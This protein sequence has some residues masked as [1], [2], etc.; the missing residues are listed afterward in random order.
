MHLRGSR[1][2]TIEF[3]YLV[4]GHTHDLIDA[5]FAY[6]SKALMGKSFLSLPEM[7]ATLEQ[8]MTRPPIWKHLRDIYGFKDSQPRELSSTRVRGI[9]QPNHVRIFWSQDAAN[10]IVQSKHW[11]TS[12]EW[13]EPLVLLNR[14]QVAQIALLWLQLLQPAWEE[15]YKSSALAW[16]DKLRALLKEADRPCD[17]LDHCKRL[18]QHEDP[19]YLP[20]GQST[21]DRL[22]AILQQGL[23]GQKASVPAVPMLPEGLRTAMSAAFP[24]SSGACK[25]GS[26]GLLQIGGAKSGA[27]S[28]FCQDE[29]EVGMLAILRN[30]T[31]QGPLGSEVLPFVLGKVL[32]LDRENPSLPCVFIQ[33]WLPVPKDKYKQANLF[34]KWQCDD[35]ND[36]KRKAS[37]P[38]VSAGNLD[39]FLVWP[40]TLETKD[41]A[42]VVGKIPLPALHFLRDAGHMDVSA[43][44]WSF[45]KRGN[46]FYLQVAKRAAQHLRSTEE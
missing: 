16:L 46:A 33:R 24:G 6:I 8:S 38:K 31:K 12:N 14:A 26:T 9:S 3:G 2:Q 1:L 35:S 32:R 29:L 11:L 19:A 21:S 28:G 15:S 13:S 40:I 17:G 45:S 30:P 41:D 25:P 27:D 36:G 22:G 37:S 43:K 42:S 4:V 18:L 44:K 10:V 34:G 5:M 20:T 23:S 7:M 39:Q